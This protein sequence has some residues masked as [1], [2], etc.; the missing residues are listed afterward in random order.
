MSEGSFSK[1]KKNIET[2]FI[3]GFEENLDHH[4][5][6]PQK[7]ELT[8]NMPLSFW[9]FS[10]SLLVFRMKVAIVQLYSMWRSQT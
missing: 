10:N 9:T 2:G 7:S 5:A 3:Y 8:T 1:I 4:S 6:K